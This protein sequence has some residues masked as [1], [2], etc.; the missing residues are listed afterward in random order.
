[1]IG[2][3]ARPSPPV[4]TRP[5]SYARTIPIGSAA[6]RCGTT[7]PMKSKPPAFSFSETNCSG[8]IAPLWSAVSPYWRP[9]LSSGRQA[10]PFAGLRPSCVAICSK[11]V[12][13]IPPGFVTG[14]Y[15]A[16]TGTAV[17]QA[18]S[19][20]VRL[21]KARCQNRHELKVPK[22]EAAARC[23]AVQPAATPAGL[24]K[25]SASSRQ[26]GTVPSVIESWNEALGMIPSRM[27]G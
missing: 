14:W 24:A 2:V 18:S 1:M 8:V 27:P 3:D 17:G 13:L 16:D 26:S 23:A 12:H 6:T 22:P 4:F 10:K 9:T 5:V 19:A 15:R 7:W 20:F 21:A 11:L 25:Y